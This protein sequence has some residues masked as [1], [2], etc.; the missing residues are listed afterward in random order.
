MEDALKSLPH[1]A[2]LRQELR[3]VN[4]VSYSI[5]ISD[6]PSAI[7]TLTS[8]SFVR[9]LDIVGR[10]SR[11]NSVLTEASNS[12]TTASS[13]TSTR[14]ESTVD[15]VSEKRDATSLNYGASLDQLERIGVPSLHALGYNGSGVIISILDTGFNTQHQAL[16]PLTVADAYDFV[17][18][19]TNV[20]DEM[21]ESGASNHGTAAWSNIGGRAPGNLYGGSYAATYLLCKTEDV[22]SE[23]SAEED[24]FARAIEW[25]EARGAEILSASLGYDSWHPWSDLDGQTSVIARVGN[26]AV[27]LGM[28]F[29]VA[30]GNAGN[31]GIGTPADMDRV[32]ALGALST[33]NDAMAG[34]SSRGPTFDAR[35]KPD[36]SAPGQQIRVADYQN[37]SGYKA[38]SGTSFATPLTAGVAGLLLQAHPTWTNR[39]L[40]DAILYTAT[41]KGSTTPNNDFGFGVVNGA[42]AV[43]YVPKTNDQLHELCVTPYG[44][45]DDSRSMCVCNDGYYNSDCRTETLAC[46]DWCPGLCST[47]ERNSPCLC[48]NANMKRCTHD[49][50]TESA[51]WTCA[52]KKYADGVT[53]DCNCNLYDPDCSD[54][55][56]PISGCS[57]SGSTCSLKPS[58][59]QSQCVAPFVPVDPVPVNPVP[60]DAPKAIPQASPQKE[61][62]KG[63]NDSKDGKQSHGAFRVL[64]SISLAILNLLLK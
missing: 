20:S 62:D 33:N 35:I 49:Q 34:F 21:Y 42:S 57:V 1:G 59:T 63:P 5:A 17:Y 47:P 61:D 6:I 50:T 18:N 7:S 11:P 3:W 28:L 4:A 15:S 45:W 53:C 9:E 41:A 44:S 22:R 51:A 55:A 16:S 31:N 14:Q 13:H 38:L 25:S 19:D 29:I 12:A 27:D 40:R 36:V 23:T 8:F 60:V 2:S 32:L 37:P 64:A 46:N 48:T 54:P 52:R 30:N 39:Q 56:L 10:T 26:R 43:S 58:T 24:Y